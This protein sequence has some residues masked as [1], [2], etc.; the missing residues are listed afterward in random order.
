MP[1]F[2]YESLNS[3][4]TTDCGFNIWR[5]NLMAIFSF[6]SNIFV[7]RMVKKKGKNPKF[8][9]TRKF[10]KTNVKTSFFSQVL[11]LKKWNTFNYFSY[12]ENNFSMDFSHHTLFHW[13]WSHCAFLFLLM[14]PLKRV[15]SNRDMWRKNS[16][17]ICHD[18]NCFERR[19]QTKARVFRYKTKKVNQNM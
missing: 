17:F 8:F 5:G 13:H 1:V 3:F 9:A 18:K 19:K 15:A 6:R 4:S 7:G 16:W 11:L 2:L 12:N 10:I 14:F